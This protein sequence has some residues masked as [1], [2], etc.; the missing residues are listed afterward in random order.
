MAAFNFLPQ[1]IVANPHTMFFKTDSSEHREK[2]RNVL[3]L[4]LGVITNDDLVRRHTLHL[5]SQEY[6]RLEAELRLRRNGLETWRA[7]AT[8]AFFRA[9]ELGLIPAGEP[10][11]SLGS[12]LERL[13]AMV[14]A[15]GVG[16]GAAGRTTT[17][18]RRLETL[19][20][21]EQ[22]ASKALSDSR[23]RLKRLRSL[24]SSAS[25]YE[26][27]LTDQSV[28]VQ[29]TGWFRQAIDAESCVLC[30]SNTQ[31]ARHSLHELSEAI[32]ELETLSAGTRQTMPVVDR[33]IIALETS[34]LEQERLLNVARRTRQA[35][36]KADEIDAGREQTLEAVYRFIGSTEQALA[37][38]GDVEGESG[39]AAQLADLNVRIRRLREELDEDEREQ[40][41]QDVSSKI[42]SYV[43]RFVDSLAVGG[44]EGIPVLD[45]RELNLRFDREKSNKPDFLWEIGS[46]EN[47]MAY[48]LATLIALHG[49]FLQREPTNPVPTF[50]VIDQPT[51]VYFPSD[52]FD[53]AVAENQDDSDLGSHT[54]DDL[55]RTKRIFAAI[56]RAYNS[57]G[58][59]LQIIIVDHADHHAWEEH[60]NIRQIANW[61]GDT[62]YLIPRAWLTED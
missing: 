26:A 60:D 34:V 41:H 28:R 55:E 52:T 58:G 6:R 29:G 50:L 4:A 11:S 42:S 13:Q 57:L 45:F 43:I 31:P 7:N 2:L 9:Q 12:L 32:T 27:A 37:M 21:Q 61:R 16:S 23:R 3:P 47:W 22:T 8:G 17:A 15:A 25:V 53:K 14:T 39:L 35:A 5:L 19:R 44:A 24:H 48:H 56:S 1:H 59:R 54:E 51:Q 40:R 20:E 10:P 36:E 38:L 18:T 62:D 49:V 30:G 33:E 46:G